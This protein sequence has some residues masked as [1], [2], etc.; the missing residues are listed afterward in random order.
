[1]ITLILGTDAWDKSDHLFFDGKKYAEGVT[2]V[3]ADGFDRPVQVTCTWEFYII[4]SHILTESHVP[5]TLKE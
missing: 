2:G 1:M 5:F 3:H 4:V